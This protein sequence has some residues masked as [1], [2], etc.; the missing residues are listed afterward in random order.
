MQLNHFRT[1]EQAVFD[2]N[3]HC[4][5]IIGENA[6]GKTNILE[7][8]YLSVHG[9]G[10]R[11]RTEE[12]LIRWEADACTVESM[13]LDKSAKL[14]FGINM[15]K[16]AGTVVKKHFVQKSAKTA[17]QYV[18]Y[19]TKAVLFAPEHMDIVCGS[20]DSRRT[21]I[22]TI[23]SVTDPEYKKRLHNYSNALYKRNKLYERHKDDTTLKE[24]L[25]FWNQYLADHGAYVT[26]KRQIYADYLN[27]H[28]SID[29]RDFEVEYLKNEFTISRATAAFDEEK[30]YRRS[31]IGPQKDDFIIRMK[32]K[33]D[34]VVRNFGSRSEQRLAVFWLKLNEL[35]YFEEVFKKRPILL[36]DDIF[37]ELD[38]KNKALIFNLVK[39]YQT[40]LT[41]TEDNLLELSDIGKTII[42]L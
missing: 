34:K 17:A 21:Y 27:A 2:F 31:I 20:P 23:L 19:H 7:S 32:G 10:F 3:E 36:L 15:R 29:H 1:F 35:M 24:E 28:P 4:T 30:R 5:I 33:T 8:I 16:S 12:E 40:V 13:W 39:K 41:T 6:R 22:N 42:R 26:A 18:G 37:S 11:E 25:V 38:M 14:R 9:D